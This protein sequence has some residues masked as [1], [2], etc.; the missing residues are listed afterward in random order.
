MKTIAFCTLGCKVNQYETEAMTELFKQK[1]YTINSFD[2]KSDIYVINTCTVTATGDK[3]SRQMI[4]RAKSANSEA[5]IAVVGCYAQVAPEEVA[6][7]EGVSLIVGTNQKREIV[8]LVE[9]Y[10][11]KQEQKHAIDDILKDKEYKEMWITSYEERTR[12]FVKIEDGCNQFCS[13]CIIPFARGPVRSRPVENIRTEVEN[14]AQNGFKEVVLTGINISSYGMD[15]HSSLADVIETVAEVDG[16]N[17]IRL[18]SIEPR[19][20]SEEFI[21]RISKIPKVC[22]H[23]HISLQSGCDETLKRM[24]RKYTT[25]QCFECIENL[26][27]YFDNPAITADVIAGFPGETTEEF[28][29]TMNF[30]KTVKFSEAHIFAYSNRKGTKADTMS[31]QIPKSEKESRS[32]QMID[33]CAQTQREYMESC[34]GK[35]YPVLFEREAKKGIYEGHMTNYVR[36]QVQSNEDISH[37]ITDVKITSVSGDVLD[38]KLIFP[39]S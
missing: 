8:S 25:A 27:R 21:A 20:L 2:Q 34:I 33:L 7:I 10:I 23:F 15:S 6:K 28:E 31:G 37:R 11:E 14:L 17:R 5:V 39:I 12:A 35:T 1:G 36:V 30:L 38:G 9:E 22:N 24:N 3:K 4:R 32:R 29:A 19:V 16:I 13:Y 18:G 26:R